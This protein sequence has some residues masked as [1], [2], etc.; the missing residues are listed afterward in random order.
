MLDRLFDFLLPYETFGYLVVFLILVACGLGLPIPEDIILV[1]SGLLVGEETFHFVRAVMTCM[2]GVLIGDS[3]IFLLGRFWGE[4]IIHSKYLSKIFHVKLRDRVEKGVKK[5]GNKII[6]FARFMPGLRAPI[7]FSLGTFKKSYLTFISID[8]LAAIISVPVWVYV[9]LFFHENLPLLEMKMKK[10][11][12]G[13]YI[14]LILILLLIIV[15]HYV[16][17][18]IIAFVNRKINDQDS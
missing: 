4:K 2:G 13:L 10:V 15:G 11:K 12:T 6:F 1:V 17:R 3:I 14:M 9:G 5:Y 7:Y 8:F 18:K 16:K